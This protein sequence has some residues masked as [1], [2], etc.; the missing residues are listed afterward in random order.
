VLRVS[1]SIEPRGSRALEGEPT[2]PRRP[3]GALVRATPTRIAVGTAVTML[4]VG[5]SGFFI[6]GEVSDRQDILKQLVSS[7]E[8]LS[9][10]AQ[11]LYSALS[12][13]DASAAT[14][15]LARGMESADIRARYTSALTLA[16][17]EIVQASS[18]IPVT[19]EEGRELLAGISTKLAQYSGVMETAR[20]NERAGN[21]VSTSYLAQGSAMMRND[22]LPSAHQLHDLQE[23]RLTYVQ[24]QYA[25]PPWLLMALPVVAACSVLVIMTMMAHRTRRR[26]NAGL[27]TAAAAVVA[28]TG[29]FFFGVLFSAAHMSTALTQGAERLGDLADARILAQQARSEEMLQLIRR[30]PGE[31]EGSGFTA[32]AAGLES[33]LADHSA[34]PLVG[35]AQIA[36]LRAADEARGRWMDSHDATDTLL[37]SGD[38]RTAA[39]VAVGAAEGESGAAFDALDSALMEAI[40][41]ARIA[42]HAHLE[43]ASRSLVA[44]PSGAVILTSLACASLVGGMFPRI[45]EYL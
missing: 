3:L 41:D 6:A 1:P 44:L 45:R 42:T 27:L 8:P 2:R 38:F 12:V 11:R 18:D 33:V 17:N 5:V 26:L 35:E 32:R 23:S 19:D 30:D 25:S 9:D 21:P 39:D 22:L 43:T 31:H 10:S 14:A 37:A 4:L 36:M 29:W 16:A 13:A 40:T 24:R 20:A 7:Q 34:N 28:A 15:F